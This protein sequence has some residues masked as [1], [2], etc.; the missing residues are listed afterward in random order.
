MSNVQHTLNSDA[1]HDAAFPLP[2][3]TH[4]GLGTYW[5]PH[6]H[7]QSSVMP[8][9][10]TLADAFDYSAMLDCPG[11]PAFG[12]TAPVSGSI[13]SDADPSAFAALPDIAMGTDA[14][15]A[16]VFLARGGM[17]QGNGVFGHSADDTWPA[18]Y[19][20]SVGSGSNA[21]M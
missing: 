1:G 5:G 10:S 11:P 19:P 9:L 12:H 14:H 3:T 7:P 6:H 16:E 4:T 20:W 13:A 21:S 8:Q 15:A 2:K 17:L 18:G